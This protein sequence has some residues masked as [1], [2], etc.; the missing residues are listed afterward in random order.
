ME[1]KIIQLILKSIEVQIN[2]RKEFNLGSRDLDQVIE[3]L[4]NKLL[5]IN[6]KCP[7]TQAKGFILRKFYQPLFKE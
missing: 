7:L 5:R 4:E 6:K 1:A 2:C 3:R